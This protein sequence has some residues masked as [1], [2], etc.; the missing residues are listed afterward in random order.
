M[1]I[2][3]VKTFIVEAG[4]QN[5]LFVKVLTD[6]GLYGWG[7][8]SVEG[9]EPSVAA[10]IHVLAKRSVIGQ[11]PGNV[12]KIW[13]QMYH[14]GFW[15]GGFVH[16]SA[17]SGI[18]MAIWDLLGKL[19]KVPTCMLLG[20]RVRDRIRTYTH[21][22]N[23][24]MA[25]KWVE[26]GFAG[27]KTGGPENGFDE[28]LNGIRKTIGNDR[29]LMVDNHGQLSTAAAIKQ[30]KIASKY[31]LYFYEEPV[32]PENPMEYKRLRGI[33]EGVPLA[34]GER[35]FNRFD[36]REI[37]E[38]QLVDF[39]QPDICHCGGISEIRRIASYA[40]VYHIRFAPHNPNGP[41]ATA[42][43]IQ[44]AMATHNFAIL[45]FAA[46]A[47]YPRSDL[48]S[49]DL[50]P[51]DGYFQ[52]PAVP[53]LGIELDEAKMAEHPYKDIQYRPRYNPDG[54]VAEI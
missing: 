16:M 21:A 47:V 32:P 53:G 43:S 13:R 14:H 18:D 25:G 33:S 11:D 2:T 49:I 46:N 23:S 31:N 9:Q 54:S 24:E 12:E 10:C 7:E 22:P 1:K 27:V 3:E 51:V 39:V 36:F 20:G 28:I 26:M 52:A 48:Y 35:L 30:I 29:E 42:A 37:V 40:E 8:A 41:V 15:K 6:G 5:W 17:I 34:A 38:N 44:V 50:K 19:Y 45:E 4:R